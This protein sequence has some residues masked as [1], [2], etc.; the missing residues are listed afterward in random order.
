[1]RTEK[2]NHQEDEEY[3]DEDFTSKKDA[4]SS[5]PNNNNNNNNNTA[6]NNKG[7]YFLSYSR[8]TLL[9]FSFSRMLDPFLRDPFYLVPGYVINN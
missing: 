7:F 1:M 2:G 8:L 4:T 3:E 5:T 6:T 9:F